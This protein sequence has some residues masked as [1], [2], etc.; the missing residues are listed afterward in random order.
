MKYF[1][2][3]AQ[4]SRIFFPAIMTQRVHGVLYVRPATAPSSLPL[5]AT[6]DTVVRLRELADTTGRWSLCVTPS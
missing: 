5:K 4:V 6:G 1:F 2:K 3:S